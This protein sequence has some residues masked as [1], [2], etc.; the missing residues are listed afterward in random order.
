M[1]ERVTISRFKATCLAL[2]DKVKRTGQP[3]LITRR[4]EPI[5]QVLP[6]PPPERP[7]AWLGSFQ[8][9]GTIVGDIIAPPLEEGEWEGLRS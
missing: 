2:L 4:G 8:S 7:A 1:P 3:I 5:A 6:P 9:T